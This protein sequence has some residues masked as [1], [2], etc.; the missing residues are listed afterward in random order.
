MLY[1]IDFR[2]L[3][4]QNC[5]KGTW[6]NN[7]LIHLKISHFN[8]DNFAAIF[9]HWFYSLYSGRSIGFPGREV[10]MTLGNYFKWWESQFP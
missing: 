10:W 8:P 5:L 7:L 1:E 9:V 6:V 4:S 2:P 3:E